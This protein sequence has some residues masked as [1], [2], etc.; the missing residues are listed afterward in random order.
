MY[1]RDWKGSPG[2]GRPDQQGEVAADERD[3]QRDAV[4]DREPHAREQ[5]VDQRVAEVALEQREQSIGR[6]R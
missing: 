5:V 4:A 1:M 2:K 3:R 6:R